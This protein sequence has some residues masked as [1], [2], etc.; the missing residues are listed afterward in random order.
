[1]FGEQ[2]IIR[3]VPGEQAVF[4]KHGF[5]FA[6]FFLE[7]FLQKIVHGF[8]GE[9]G[10]GRAFDEPCV[11]LPAVGLFRKTALIA[12]RA[13][14]REKRFCQ[15]LIGG[16]HALCKDAVVL[17]KEVLLLRVGKLPGLTEGVQTV[18]KGCL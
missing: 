1:M 15:S 10:T 7:G 9:G 3:Q 11:I 17:G 6:V 2:G 18:F 14:E 8:R 4:F 16:Q 13:A 5:H 12:A